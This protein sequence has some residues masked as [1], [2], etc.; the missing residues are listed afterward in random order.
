MHRLQPVPDIRQGAGHDNAHGVVDIRR[1]H[2]VPQIYRHN[3]ALTK[4]HF[5]T[6]KSMYVKNN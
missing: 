6:S 4:I 3:L 5:L 1:L 2:L